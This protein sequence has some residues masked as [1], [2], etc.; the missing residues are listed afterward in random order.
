MRLAGSAVITGLLSAATLNAQEAPQPLRIARAAGEVH[1]DGQLDEGVWTNATS[2][3]LV[4]LRPVAGGPPSAPSEVLLTYDDDYLYAAARFSGAEA[5]DTRSGSLTRD[6]LVSDN[7]F[8]LLLDTYNDAENAVEFSVNPAGTRLDRAI[9]NDGGSIDGAWNAFWDAATVVTTDGWSAELRIPFSSLRFQSQ[10][11]RVL[12]GVIASRYRAVNAELSTFPELPSGDASPN[13]RPI[14]AHEILLEGVRPRAPVYVTPYLVAGRQRVNVPRTGAAGFEADVDR[15]LE[16]GLDGKYN[17]A[18]NLVLDVTANTD[19][20][21]V[22]V[23]HQQVNLSQFSLFLQEKR[24]FFLE[25]SAIFQFSTTSFGSDR[26]FHSRRMGLAEDGSPLRIYGGARIVGRAGDWDVGALSIQADRAEASGTENLSV[27]RVRRGVLNEGSWMGGMLTSRIA[28]GQHNIVTA[29]DALLRVG[30]SDYLSLQWAQ[31]FDSE[32]G[33]SALDGGMAMARIQRNSS[34][35]LM[36][37]FL[38]KWQGPQFEPRLGYITRRDHTT[39]NANLRYGWQPV[40]TMFQQIQPSLNVSHAYR[41]RDGGLDLGSYNGFI[42]L[43]FKNGASG[44]LHGNIQVETLP[45]DLRFGEHVVVPAGEHTYGSFGGALFASNGARF[46]PGGSISFGPFYDGWRSNISVSPLLTVNQHLE[47]GVDY[48]FN[49][50]SFPERGQR[51]NADVA[52]LRLNAA[53]NTHFSGALLAQYNHSA[54]LWSVNGRLRY[55]LS[56]GRDLWLVLNEQMNT[57]LDRDPALLLPRS[58]SNTIA[59]KYSHTLVR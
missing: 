1:L 45:F 40:R 11:G 20:A 54:R 42:N 27:M 3:A 34:R 35:G 52:R 39:F 17:L 55:H 5:A 28:Q 49:R 43:S 32:R 22:E 33:G 4:R 7:E 58:R 13:Y 31:S 41:N 51:L 36:Y 21:Q 18:S 57:D 8:R 53:L 59:F 2:L 48:N 15:Q 50:L 44:G 9:S 47:L 30:G 26:L 14:R 10:D 38:A 12:M 19:F 6:R 25:R 23:D 24:P 16:V 37:V 46:R 56:E 29:A